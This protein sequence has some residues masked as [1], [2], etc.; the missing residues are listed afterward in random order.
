MIKVPLPRH[1]H[2]KKWSCNR[3]IQVGN[4]VAVPVARAL[5][6]SLGMAFQ[7]LAGDAPVF[8]L[9]KK[10]PNILKEHSSASSEE[11]A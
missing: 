11:V 5:G 7:G 4:A 3:Y 9:P 10:F 6:Y 1:Q 2:Y 8:S